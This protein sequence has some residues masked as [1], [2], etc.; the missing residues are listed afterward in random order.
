M[1]LLDPN[2]VTITVKPVAFEFDTMRW[3]INAT[4]GQGFAFHAAYLNACREQQQLP[5]PGA[6][7]VEQ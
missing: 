4:S 7:K 3:W 1:N 6:V 5:K 2:I